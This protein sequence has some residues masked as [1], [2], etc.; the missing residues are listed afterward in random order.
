MP[1]STCRCCTTLIYGKTCSESLLAFYKKPLVRWEIFIFIFITVAVTNFLFSYRLPEEMREFSTDI[2]RNK[3]RKVDG[4]GRKRRPWFGFQSTK[5]S[6]P[7]WQSNVILILVLHL[8]CDL[9]VWKLIR[10]MGWSWT[11]SL[12]FCMRGHC[13]SNLYASYGFD[14]R[15]NKCEAAHQARMRSVTGIGEWLWKEQWFG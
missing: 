7:I 12:F 8:K 3:K 5:E 11:Q 1:T 2:F 13:L 9:P 14:Y 15:A 10:C 6:N 4:G